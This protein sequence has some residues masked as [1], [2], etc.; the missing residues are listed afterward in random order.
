VVPVL[1]LGNTIGLTCAG[2]A[3]VLAVRASRGPAALRGSGRAAAAG[4][5]GAVAGAAAGVLVSSGLRVTGF[6]PNACVTLLACAAA[7]T[8]FGVAV[9]ALDGS[10]LRAL[11]AR[12]AARRIR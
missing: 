11:A 8:V 6:F 2:V 12:A 7:A 4:L 1:G 9:L 3:L 5:A 10:D